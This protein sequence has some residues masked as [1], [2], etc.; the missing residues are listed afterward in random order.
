MRSALLVVFLLLTVTLAAGYADQGP[1]AAPIIP[2]T[3]PGGIRGVSSPSPDAPAIPATAPPVST[4]PVTQP[5]TGE[6]CMNQSDCTTGTICCS[7]LCRDAT[8]DMY[9]YSDEIYNASHEFLESIKT[10]QLNVVTAESLTGGMISSSL[11]DVPFYGSYIYGGFATYDSDAKRQFLGVRTGDVY[12]KECS[13]EMAIGALEHSRAL[14]GIAVTGKAGPVEKDDLD[15]LGVVDVGVSIRTDKAAAGS[16]IPA[17]P[18]FPQTFTSVSRRIN[19]CGDDGHQA[20]R[21]VCE[22]Y[23]IEAASSDKGYVSSG[24]LQLVRKLIRQDTV[25]NAVRIGQDHVEQFNCEKQGDIVVCSGLS[26]LCTASYDGN[27]IAFGEP[28]GVITRHLGKTPCA[29]VP[30][31][32]EFSPCCGIILPTWAQVT[33]RFL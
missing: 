24:V 10:R 31:V 13:L 5:R 25:I 14:V 8:I 32:G 4:F 33:V 27:Y 19:T 2:V 23:K 18:S 6:A 22:K 28:S 20:T 21:D 16:D 17:D 3:T 29:V 12:T 15:S 26:G 11:V 1:A 9:S 7:G 30:T